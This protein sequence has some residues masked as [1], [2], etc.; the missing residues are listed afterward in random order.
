MEEPAEYKTDKQKKYAKE[1]LEVIKKH[2][3]ALI[4][5]VWGF[6]SFSKATAYN[7]NLDQLDDIREALE[8]NKNKAKVYLLNKWIASPNAT[9]NV[10]AYRL[11][12]TSEEH[13][14]LNQ[15]YHDHTSKGEKISHQ[16]T[17]Q[18]IKALNDELENTY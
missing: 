12:S 15:Q 17:P 13:K 8:D 4:D 1:A 10:A 16:L 11:L 7:H 6:T 9:L 18:E 2:K 14:L 5:H 3:I